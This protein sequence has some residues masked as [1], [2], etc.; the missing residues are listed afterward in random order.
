VKTKIKKK[1]QPKEV[2]ALKNSVIKINQCIT[3]K[4]ASTITIIKKIEEDLLGPTQVKCVPIL[5]AVQLTTSAFI[6][7]RIV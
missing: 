4:D 2:T 7:E 6:T 3:Q 5:Q 1:I